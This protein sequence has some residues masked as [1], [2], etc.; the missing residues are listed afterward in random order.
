MNL[1]KL[2]SLQGELDK[3]IAKEHDLSGVNLFDKK[4]LALLVELGEFANETRCFKFWSKKGPS[5]RSVMLEEYVDGLHFILSLGLIKNYEDITLDCSTS[6]FEDGTL[7]FL[8]LYKKAIYFKDNQSKE[9]YIDLFQSFIDL[10]SFF[11]FSS[12]DMENAYL[13]KNKENHRRQENG[14]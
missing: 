8:D 2:F 13:D 11:G 7:G 3:H 5:E 4:L 14:Y 12:L 10:G 9:A 6:R 1:E